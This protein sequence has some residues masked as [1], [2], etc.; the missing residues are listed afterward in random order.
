MNLKVCIAGA[1]GWVGRPLSI[2][3]S[4]ADDLSLVGAVSRTHK[5]N[6]LR[7]VIGDPA[8][9]LIISESV[10]EA[11]NTPTD[12]LVDYTQPDAVKSRSG[13]VIGKWQLSS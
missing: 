13:T 12:V 2:A 7:D 4:G 11:L 8:R 1:T 3:V 10:A 5:G 6:N 9:D